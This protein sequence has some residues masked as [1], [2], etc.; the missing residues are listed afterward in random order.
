MNSEFIE[1]VGKYVLSSNIKI[2]QLCYRNGV[3]SSSTSVSAGAS[4]VIIRKENNKYYALTA[5]HVV[6]EYDNI[7]KTQI[8]VM[9]YDDLDFKDYINKGGEFQSS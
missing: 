7:D 2:V 5:K 9:G 6:A 8:I 3:N 1:M 4:G